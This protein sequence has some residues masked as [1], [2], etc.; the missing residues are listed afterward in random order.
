[1]SMAPS[2]ASCCPQ[3]HALLPRRDERVYE[4]DVGKGEEKGYPLLQKQIHKS[5]ARRPLR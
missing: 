2:P 3:P 1:M 5:V 4:V